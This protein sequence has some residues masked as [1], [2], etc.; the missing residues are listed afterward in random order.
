MTE[1]YQAAFQERHQDTEILK[2]SKRK[3]AAMHLGGVT[4]ECLLKAMIF[5]SLPKNVVREWKTDS[6]S[7][8]HPITN[9]GHSLQNALQR[10]SK[11]NSRVDKF[12]QIREWIRIVENPSQH[13]IDMRYKGDDPKDQEYQKWLIAYESL[14]RWLR[15]QASQI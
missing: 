15:K 10:H 2:A 7:P 12:P 11:L 9:P 5:A 1:D 8:K 3:V 6:N 13:F 14:I 4:T